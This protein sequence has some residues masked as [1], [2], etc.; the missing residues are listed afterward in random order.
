MRVLRHQENGSFGND[1]PLVRFQEIFPPADRV[2]ISFFLNT[3]MLASVVFCSRIQVHYPVILF[4]IRGKS[5]APLLLWRTSKK[6]LPFAFE[7]APVLITAHRCKTHVSSGGSA[8]VRAGH[9]LRL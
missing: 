9:D 7:P 4:A 1:R 3:A 5:C 8:D 6:I 2:R